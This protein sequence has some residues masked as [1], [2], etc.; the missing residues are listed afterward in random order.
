MDRLTE[1]CAGD[2][3]NVYFKEDMTKS[4]YGDQYCNDCMFTFMAEQ[5]C[6]Y[7]DAVGR[8]ASDMVGGDNPCEYE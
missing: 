5:E 1:L 7:V 3:G 4:C 8:W 6:E 2:C